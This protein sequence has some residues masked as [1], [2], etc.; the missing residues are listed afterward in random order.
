MAKQANQTISP[1]ETYINNPPP[2]ISFDILVIFYLPE[3]LYKE[4]KL[5]KKTL[6]KS[7]QLHFSRLPCSFRWFDG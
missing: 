6:L 4:K 3:I 5:A 7:H 1:N 2:F